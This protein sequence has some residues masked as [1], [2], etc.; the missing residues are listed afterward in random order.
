[1]RLKSVNILKKGFR[2]GYIHTCKLVIVIV[3]ECEGTVVV[4]VERG[5]GRNVGA[6][7]N[8]EGSR[9]QWPSVIAALS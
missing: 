1:M 7:G 3:S 2:V 6:Q 8:D 9:G 4:L 5:G